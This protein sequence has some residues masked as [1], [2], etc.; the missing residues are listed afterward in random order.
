VDLP[1]GFA[2]ANLALGHAAI[3]GGRSDDAMRALEP[4]REVIEARGLPTWSPWIL[5][6]R[7]YGL[8]LAGR[9]DEGAALLERARER[10]ESLPFLFGHSQWVAWL[11]HAHLLTGRIDEAGRTGDEALRLSRRRGARGH[12]GWSLYVLGEVAARQ[13][14]APAAESFARQALALADV[15]QMRPLRD[16][17]RATL[18]GLRL[19]RGADPTRASSV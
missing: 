5:A 13:D 4:A 14:A 9:A 10:A 18:G 19:G 15:L 17:A 1:F 3:V 8:T 7:G 16:R 12:E 6:L 11:A 2:L